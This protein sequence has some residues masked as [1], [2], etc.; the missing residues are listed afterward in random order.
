MSLIEQIYAVFKNGSGQFDPEFGVFT[1]FNK[2][3]RQIQK[4]L[5]KID[6]PADRAIQLFVQRGFVDLYRHP[7]LVDRKKHLNK[8]G[9]HWNW[10]T[11][12]KHETN[13]IHRM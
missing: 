10:Y 1:D 3:Y 4:K 6:L 2:A 11:I 12:S 8:D 9:E 7:S 5:A 13:K